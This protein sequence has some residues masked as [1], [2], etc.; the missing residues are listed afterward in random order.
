MSA[1][2]IESAALDQQSLA[3]SAPVSVLK[4]NQ[5]DAPMEESNL[6]ELLDYNPVPPRRTVTLTVCYSPGGL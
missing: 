5:P 6:D 3:Q 4:G 2:A 1:N